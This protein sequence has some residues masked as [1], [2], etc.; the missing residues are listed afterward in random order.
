[1]GRRLFQQHPDKVHAIAATA[2]L[3]A[4]QRNKGLC[5]VLRRQGGHALGVHIWR[6][7]KNQVKRT[8]QGGQAVGLDQ[9]HTRLQAVL[10][11]IDA[12]DG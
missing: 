10:V 5:Q 7:A 3:I 11:H 6:V 4:V 9:L 12:G 8:G 1:M 2:G